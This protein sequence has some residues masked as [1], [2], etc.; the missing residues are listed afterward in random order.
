MVAYLRTGELEVVSPQL[1]D[2]L[3][4]PCSHS[5]RN[6]RTYTVPSSGSIGIEPPWNPAQN[7]SQLPS[8]SPQVL[9]LSPP[10]QKAAI[11]QVQ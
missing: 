8:A 4:K 5:E 11:A 10:L 6:L 7:P 2:T 3:G 9:P 1:A